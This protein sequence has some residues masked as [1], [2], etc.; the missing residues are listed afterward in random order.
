MSPAPPP[1]LLPHP[2]VALLAG[3]PAARPGSLPDLRRRAL[4]DPARPGF[5]AA[6]LAAAA[7][8][9]EA[10]L[11]PAAPG[12]A[13][14]AA[15][16]AALRAAAPRAVLRLEWWA[17]GTALPEPAD[18]LLAALAA[19]QPLFVQVVVNH[20][21]E[22]DPP[23]A[24]ALERLAR[25]GVPLAAEVHLLPGRND[26]AATLRRLCLALLR[27]GVRP[28]VLVDGFWQER[29]VPRADA[30]ERVRALRG[31]ISGLAV[32]QLVE[33]LPDGRRTPVI[34]AYVTRLDAAGADLVNYQG[35]PH[36]YPNPTGEK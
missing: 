6:G 16:I 13:D 35:R 3:G 7:G 31:W 12:T 19:A 8:C 5:A 33:E 4:F 9:R 23:L 30:L 14:S 11:L 20:P 36:Y 15:L 25:A 17:R 18:A 2:G 28:Y 34:P 21:D 29:R 32:P 1:G 27:Q 24:A 26:D 22:L 10:T